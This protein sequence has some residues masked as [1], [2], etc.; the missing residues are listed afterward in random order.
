MSRTSFE[1]LKDGLPSCLSSIKLPLP[2]EN[3]LC[4]LNTNE[5]LTLECVTDRLMNLCVSV[6]NFYV[7][8]CGWPWF[9]FILSYKLEWNLYCDIDIE[10]LV[11][12][13][14]TPIRQ[15]NVREYRRGNQRWTTQ[16]NWSGVYSINHFVI[17]FV[18]DLRQVDGFLQVF[19]F[20][21]QTP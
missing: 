13:S 7:V 10:E 12:S 6:C 16:K 14:S 19:R 21:P 4:H 9:F 18:S 17:T 15:I 3:L 11:I 8:T 20:S 5:R 1:V 2:L